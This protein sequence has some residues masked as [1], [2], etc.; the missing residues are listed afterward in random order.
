[1]FR[2]S[3]TFKIIKLI[4]YISFKLSITVITESIFKTIMLII[5]PSAST[6]VCSTC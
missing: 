2:T 3:F 5:A 1:M 6:I 4:D